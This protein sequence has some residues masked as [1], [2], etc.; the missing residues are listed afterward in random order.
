MP[1]E[2]LIKCV[3]AHSL[4]WCETE[5][6]AIDRVTALGWCGRNNRRG[7]MGGALIRVDALDATALRKV[8]FLIVRRLHHKF[9]IQRG[10][11][12]RM[13]IASLHEL[14]RANCIHCGGRGKID[15]HGAPTVTC[16]HCNGSGLH[17]YTDGDRMALIGSRYNHAAYDDILQY[18]RDSTREIVIVSDKR[19]KG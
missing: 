19:L 7:E 12:E 16:E 2:S 4:E 5:E 1:Q 14:L 6:R 10:V 15:Q 13:A 18:L 17:C 9:H 11:A 3:M 8:I